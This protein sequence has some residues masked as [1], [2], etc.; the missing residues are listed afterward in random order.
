MILRRIALRDFG[1]FANFKADL[2]PGLNVIFGNNEEGKST[3]RE[4]IRL[5]LFQD[6]RT[7]DRNVLSR[8]RW[9]AAEQWAVTLEFQ[10]D[11]RTY[12]LVKDFQTKTARLDERSSGEQL[13]D[14]RTIHAC[15]KDLLGLG[16]Q[17][18]FYS[19]VCINQ[20]DMTQIKRGQEIADSLQ[21]LVTGGEQDVQ[22]SK[23]LE[24]LNRALNALK[25]AYR[26]N[27]GPLIVL[28]DEL[29]SRDEALEK[30]RRY[31]AAG[32]VAR[33]KLVSTQEALEEKRRDLG[34]K[35]GTEQACKKR[36]D[37]VDELRQAK[38]AELRLDE[39][40]DRARN[41]ESA[42][43]R[44]EGD[45]GQFAAALAVPPKQVREID[46]L[47]SQASLAHE[48]EAATPP[49]KT[50]G[51]MQAPQRG[52][53]AIA[54]ALALVG[55]VGGIIYPPLFALL[56]VGAGLAA[57]KM[58]QTRQGANA[59]VLA[60]RMRA[61]ERREEAESAAS[62]LREMLSEVGCASAAELHAMRLEGEGLRRRIGEHKAKLE[63]LLA[64]QT[65][66]EIEE[67]RKEASRRVRDLAERLDEP[68]MRLAD[69]DLDAYKRLQ[70]EIAD[71]KTEVE[72]LERQV[73]DLRVEVRV[74]QV[75][76][77]EVHSLEEEVEELRGRLAAARERQQVLTLA[78]QVLEEARA[79]TMASAKDVLERELG[80]LIEEITCRRY[81]QV[82]VD[83][84]R[85]SIQLLSPE[86]REP[87]DVGLE[88]ELSTGT[89]EQV[90][91]AARLAIARL[92]TQ[93]RH[94]PLI[95]D[96][97]FVTFDAP[98]TA[99]VLELCKRLATEV[100]I[101]LF[102]CDE[103]HKA[104]ADNVVELPKLIP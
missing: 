88:G 20:R 69:I 30:K 66:A 31:L 64:G 56:L 73:D 87:I 6:P 65:V 58:V 17:H 8:K 90:Y 63:G 76:V 26:N 86:K 11:G 12:A 39:R 42:I 45:L 54:I 25:T 80:G 84:S 102:T 36:F 41:L 82:K 34:Q 95:L 18:V 2:T 1:R 103:R 43:A 91:L 68:E 33:K 53:L 77:D 81:A 70:R 57:W 55:I 4:A 46:A 60:A 100:Q 7:T 85:L 15:V 83:A 13:Q 75:G 9:G 29:E 78:R 35:V 74:N 96:D 48:I 21:K 97:P 104:V 16:S 37:L 99:A 10:A 59:A 32:E 101:L 44:G 79:A 38:E 24:E 22:A 93:G 28:P 3:L 72:A 49:G 67:E 98:R 47:E 19:T 27:P 89:V 94:P 50:E 52:L 40:L 61:K 71:L 51:R 62:R 92:L 5:A 14:A 23:V